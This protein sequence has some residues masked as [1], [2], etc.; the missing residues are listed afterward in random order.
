[1]AILRVKGRGS[2]ARPQRTASP[3]RPSLS[4]PRRWAITRCAT[5]QPMTVT[6]NMQPWTRRMV[7]T[8]RRRSTMRFK[9]LSAAVYGIDAN[10]IDVEVNFSGVPVEGDLPHRWS[11]GCSGSGEPRP[12]TRSH[13]GLRLRNSATTALTINNVEGYSIFTTTVTGTSLN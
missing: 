8:P 3:A 12:R 5:R 4:R 11:A 1:M 2:L 7:R 9:A 10:L 6:A 13:Q